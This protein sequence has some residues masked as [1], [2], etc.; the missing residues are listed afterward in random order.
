MRLPAL[1]SFVF[2]SALPA[3][4]LLAPMPAL[5]HGI[6]GHIHVTGWAIES[7]P[8]GPLADLFAD[9]DAFDAALF[10]ASFPDTGYAIDDPYG[11]MAHWPPFL[12]A[13]LRHLRAN[14]PPP[15][16][17]PEKR[18]HVAFVMGLAS[19]GLQ[20]EIFDSI[21][22]HQIAE[23]DGRGQ[24]EADPGTDAM[25]FVD[26]YLRFKPPQWAPVDDLVDVF[27][28]EGHRVDAET[29]EAGMTRVKVVVIDGFAG[30]GAVFDRRYR[31]LLPWTADHY[32]DPAIPGSLASEIP[33][34][35]AFIEAVWERLHD[36][37]PAAGFVAHPYPDGRRRLQS[38]DPATVSSWVTLVLGIGARVGTINAESVSFEG[39]EG[40]VPFELRHTRWSGGADD[41]TRI[42][43]LRPQVALAEDSEYTV[44]LAAG[45]ELI[46][47]SLLAEPWQYSF[48]TRCAEGAGCAPEPADGGVL[49]VDAMV[50]DAGGG[51]DASVGD[52]MVVDASDAMAP[53][54]TV[55]DAAAADA[56][57]AAPGASDG[58]DG[59]R[60]SPATGGEPA[61]PLLCLLA[62]AVAVTR[63][64]R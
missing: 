17:T 44:R 30:I 48:R 22:L 64:R 4:A 24:D 29:I 63:R 39:P 43:Q 3:L 5:A 27:A 47:G 53:D 19:H 34:T 26:G 13:Y 8:P 42:I 49:P 55:V 20:D 56:T 60:A 37:F 35:R 31:P 45:I 15:Y 40:A 36:R 23:H 16:D 61:V 57:G 41:W 33:A 1:A 11:E 46:D 12:E 38:T 58:G 18:R 9:P 62:L 7:L 21:F 2:A 32:I 25:L 28:A 59:C 54:V 51:I 6:N 52:A 10:A 50:E 14:L